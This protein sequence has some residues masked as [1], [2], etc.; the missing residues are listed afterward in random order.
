M[1]RLLTL[2]IV[3]LFISTVFIPMINA[4]I[5]K[6]GGKEEIKVSSFLKSS[7]NTNIKKIGQNSFNL[8]KL[9]ELILKICYFIDNLIDF[10]MENYPILYKITYPFLITILSIF[11]SIYVILDSINYSLPFIYDFI[12]TIIDNII[13]GIDIILGFGI[14]GIVYFIV[15]FILAPL[16]KFSN[17]IHWIID[18]INSIIHPSKNIIRTKLYINDLGENV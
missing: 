10:L 5:I 11:L 6:I 15:V 12:K 16:L 17:F 8:T 1:K 18:L 7:S 2:C 13:Y 4:R 14:L 9:I 3:V